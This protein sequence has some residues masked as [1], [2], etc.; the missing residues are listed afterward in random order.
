MADGYEVDPEALRTASSGFHVGADAVEQAARQLS[1]AQ[2]VPGSLGEV[3][4][5]YEL[6]AAFADY[7]GRH[8]DDL[9]LGSSWVTDTANG[10]VANADSYTRAEDFR[11]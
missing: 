1:T 2:L 8:A 5:A 3:D 11:P 10:L 4:A 9:R 7:A 6:A